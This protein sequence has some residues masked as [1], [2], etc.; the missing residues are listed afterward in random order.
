MGNERT[1]LDFQRHKAL[2][3]QIGGSFPEYL[4]TLLN[5]TATLLNK[6]YLSNYMTKYM[7]KNFTAKENKK[8]KPYN[9][10]RTAN[11]ASTTNNARRTVKNER[12]R[13]K[14]IPEEKVKLYPA[15][16]Q[17]ILPEETED[18]QETA[19]KLGEEDEEVYEKKGRE[20]LEEDD[21]IEPWEEGFLEG[22]TGAAQLS[23]DALT[24]EPLTD[25]VYEIEMDG[26]FYRF[27][28][29]ENA[30]KFKEKKK[31][32]KLHKTD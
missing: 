32:E 10:I 27:A 5:I 18:E 31:K 26:K 19:M 29:K 11:N 4:E 3:G 2:T 1:K 14:N 21:E 13:I 25:D 7:A 8:P 17:G 9:A 28:N 22:A 15:E 16:E 20:K 30:K 12:K 6:Y 23:K 24:G